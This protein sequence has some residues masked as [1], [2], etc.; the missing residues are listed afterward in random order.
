MHFGLFHD[1]LHITEYLHAVGP[2]DNVNAAWI[3][4]DLALLLQ[5]VLVEVLSEHL[6]GFMCEGFVRHNVQRTMRYSDR[7][8][9]GFSLCGRE[10]REEGIDN[11]KCG[12]NV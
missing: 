4:L 11:A 10:L 12:T 5:P 8:A 6:L 7:A 3:D 9:G 2:H 1:G